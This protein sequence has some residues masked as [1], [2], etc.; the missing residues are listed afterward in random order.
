MP[1]HATYDLHLHTYWSYDACAPVEYYF[2]RAR[3]LRLLSI[4]V[5]EH[6]TMDSLPDILEVSRKYPDVAFIPGA[7]MTVRTPMGYAVDLVCLGMAVEHPPELRAVFEMSRQHQRNLGAAVSAAMQAIGVDY[8]E[9]ARLELLRSYRPQRVIDFQG[10]THVQSA[11]QRTHFLKHGLASNEEEY[12]RLLRSAF[13][14][15]PLPPYLDAEKVLPTVR[16]TGAL[17]FVAHPS[18]YFKENETR[19]LDQLRE[20]VGFDGVECAHDTTPPALTP[21]YRKY[22]VE[23]GLLSSAGSDCHA[24]PA[25]NPHGIG[26]RHEFARHIGEDSWLDEILERLRKR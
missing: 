21:V 3:E 17:I 16:E 23:R 5:T 14:K 24:D 25:D 11:V 8:G 9:A 26:V 7:E 1:S 2:R 6:F 12:R 20:A 13:E 10:V 4:A 15:L 18:S 22:C 19:R